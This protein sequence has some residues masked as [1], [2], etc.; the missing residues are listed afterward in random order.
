MPRS[1]AEGAATRGPDVLD[2]AAHQ[3]SPRDRRV[4]SGVDRRNHN[5]GPPNGIERRAYERR[6]HDRRS[7][8][9]TD[10]RT[11]DR[12]TTKGRRGEG[13]AARSTGLRPSP[14]PLPR[15]YTMP[16]AER[17]STARILRAVIITLVALACLFAA[18]LTR[19]PDAG[20]AA[21]AAPKGS[22]GSVRTKAGDVSATVTYRLTKQ[23][24]IKVFGGLRLTV[25]AAGKTTLRKV[26]LPGVSAGY[27]VKPEVQLV[28][29][30]ADGALDVVVNT[31]SGGAHCCQI[32]SI[33]RSTASGWSKPVTRNWRD[34]GY[35]LV[36]L[37]GTATPEFEAFDDRFIERYTS[38]A[39]SRAPIRIWSMAGG[40]LVDVTKTFPDL[41]RADAAEHSQAWTDAEKFDDGKGRKILGRTAAAA[42]I[43]DLTVLGAFEEAKAVVT[44][45]R[46]RGDFSDLP[47]FTGTLGHDLVEF[48][49]LADPT[50]VG[51]TDGPTETAP[52][53]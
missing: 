26:K 50:L 14:R 19:V 34:Y 44:A 2:R 13:S 3:P 22:S 24:M 29:V 37:G 30:T 49:Y 45:A 28:D 52:S 48:G 27:L 16:V 17:S 38:Y 43:A 40:K 12:R 53:A 6:S 7:H 5:V 10:R 8:Q 36:D 20:A 39:G 41:V 1:P 32:S 51:L 23:G 9:R 31:N 18:T 35:K 21:T 47:S 46:N 11:A 42:W 25:M 15:K 33:A 4:R